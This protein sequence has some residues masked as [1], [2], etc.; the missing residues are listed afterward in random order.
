MQEY[1]TRTRLSEKMDHLGGTV[2]IMSGSILMFV[3]LWGMRISA[4]LA[5]GALGCMLL[6]LRERG[7]RQRVHRREKLLRARLGGEM[8]MEQWLLM[9][10]RRAHVE[11]ALLMSLNI[12]RAEDWGAVC[13]TKNQEKR[14]VFCAQMHRRE[15]L[16]VRDIAACQ[17]IC[18]RERVD[19]GVLCGVGTLSQEAK[20]QALLPP[21]IKTVGYE[22]M[23]ALAGAAWPATDEQLVALG[24]RKHQGQMESVLTHTIL[25]PE[26][27]RKY[28]L[29]GLLLCLLYLFSGLL[30]Y[31]LPGCMCLVLMALCRTG[32]F[33]AKNR[34]YL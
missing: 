19:T 17:R 12:E 32:R 3:L 33:A 5:G 18:L 26:R 10:P 25:S 31:L 14:V 29:Y 13:W 28:L 2:L 7:R 1:L 21:V 24:K 16:S 27:D 20:A 4:L 34:D 15:Q 11:A 8:K 30:A 22:R 9:Q 23:I 6:I